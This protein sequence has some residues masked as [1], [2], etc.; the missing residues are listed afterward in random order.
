MISDFAAHFTQSFKNEIENVFE[1]FLRRFWG[2]FEACSCRRLALAESRGQLVVAATK[3][4][5]AAAAAA[6]AADLTNMAK[7][8]VKPSKETWNLS[9]RPGQGGS[10]AAAAAFR[11]YLVLYQS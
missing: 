6:V 3:M 9:F 11:W 7:I 4:P 2:A 5:N 8:C 1:A 10:A